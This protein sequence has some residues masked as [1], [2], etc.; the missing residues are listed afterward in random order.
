[1]T[2]FSPEFKPNPSGFP[3]PFIPQSQRTAQDL[4]Q[5]SVAPKVLKTPKKAGFDLTNLI[6]PR[7]LVAHR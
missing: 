2:G 3:F 4:K 7:T 1:M 6:A 5:I